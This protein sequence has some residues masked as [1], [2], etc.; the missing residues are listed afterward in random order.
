ML[1]LV[2]STRELSAVPDGDG[3]RRAAPMS[4]E[5]RRAAIVEA[6][7][8]LVAERGVDA[9]SRELADAAGVAE[10]TLFRAFGDKACLI[11]EVALTGLLRASDPVRTRADLESVDAR[12]PLVERVRQIIERGQQRSEEATAWIVVLRSMHARG[13]ADQGHPD[14]RDRAEQMRSR[15]IAQHE[16]R[17]TVVAESLGRVLAQDLDRLRVP[18]SV[19]VAMIEAA[20]A[21]RRPGPEHLDPPLP[22][23]VLA[24]ALLHGIVGEERTPH[25]SEED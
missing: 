1:G 12:L 25:H 2:S 6:V 24:D 20:T 19:A 11:G 23:D 10:G 7:M 5:D 22:A 4:P 8:P 14:H 3:R 21:H 17:R 13:G 18:I 16:M 15:M 9:T